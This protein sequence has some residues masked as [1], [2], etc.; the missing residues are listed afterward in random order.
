MRTLIATLLSLMLGTAALAADTLPFKIAG[1]TVDKFERPLQTRTGRYTQALVLQLEVD[2]RAWESLPPAIETFLYIG[3]HE[4]R[5]FATELGKDRVILT[6]HD[7]DWQSLK[8]G[9]SMVLTTEH[10]D[11]LRN[12]QRYADAPRYDPGIIETR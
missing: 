1:A 8:G 10:G 4:L 12:P 2:R 11:P 9:E 3:S 7:P 6:F 5:P